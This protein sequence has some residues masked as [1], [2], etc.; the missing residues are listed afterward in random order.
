MR[1]R[2]NLHVFVTFSRPPHKLSDA[3]CQLGPQFG[4]EIMAHPLDQ[5]KFCAGNRF[6]RRSASARVAHAVGKSVDDKRRD[7]EISQACSAISGSHRRNRL[8][9]DANRIVGP[10]V[11]AARS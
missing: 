5:D 7:I 4:W 11:G 1:I 6:G 2:T 9:G 8:T 10:V 3:L